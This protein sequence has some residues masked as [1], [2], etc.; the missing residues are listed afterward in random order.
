MFSHQMV[1]LNSGNVARSNTT[2]QLESNCPAVVVNFCGWQVKN[3][4]PFGTAE[5]AIIQS[6]P[7]ESQRVVRRRLWRILGFG[8]WLPAFSVATHSTT[9]T[10]DEVSVQSFLIVSGNRSRS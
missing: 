10:F 7:P 1:L 9:G 4:L 5:Y 8:V 6:L 2:T 3:V